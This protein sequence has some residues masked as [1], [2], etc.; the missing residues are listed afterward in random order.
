MLNIRKHMKYS[1]SLFQVFRMYL[2]VVSIMFLVYL[3]AYLFRFRDKSHAS[4]RPRSSMDHHLDQSPSNTL[5]HSELRHSS[6]TRDQDKKSREI[7]TFSDLT[8]KDAA[9]VHYGGKGIN[10]YLRFG[11][12]GENHR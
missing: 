12:I 10:F 7:D 2:C 11:A 3:H 1:N 8:I 5:N 4:L 9:P 6:L